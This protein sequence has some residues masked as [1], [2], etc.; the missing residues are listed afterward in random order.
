M[1]IFLV[2]NKHLRIRLG[3]IGRD[4]KFLITPT[5]CT[6]Q[7]ARDFGIMMSALAKC[8]LISSTHKHTIAL[9]DSKQPDL[10][11]IITCPVMMSQPIFAS[12]TWKNLIE[13]LAH[14]PIRRL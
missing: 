4:R 5:R 8:Q 6:W 10:Y 12:K 13:T 3:V 9:T 1:V 7:P 11:R 2:P 14:R